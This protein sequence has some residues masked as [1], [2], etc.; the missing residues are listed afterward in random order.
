MQVAKDA[1]SKILVETKNRKVEAYARA[2]SRPF[3]IPKRSEEIKADL[4]GSFE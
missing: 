2:N 3:R 4:E 1:L